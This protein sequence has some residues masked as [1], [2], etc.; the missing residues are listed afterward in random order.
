MFHICKKLGAIQPR[1]RQ[2]MTFLGEF[3]LLYT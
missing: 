3:S 1:L 2:N